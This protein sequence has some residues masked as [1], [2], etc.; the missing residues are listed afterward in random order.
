MTKTIVLESIQAADERDIIGRWVNGHDALR[1]S[2]DTGRRRQHIAEL[3]IRITGGN[4]A[5]GAQAVRDWDA[6]AGTPA[7]S[8]AAILEDNARL[9]RKAAQAASKVE[10]YRKRLVTTRRELVATQEA[11]AAAVE[12]VDGPRVAELEQQLADER[13][14]FA[15]EL[16]QLG[17]HLTHADEVARLYKERVDRLHELVSWARPGDGTAVL[18]DHFRAVLNG[19]EMSD[20]QKS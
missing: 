3:I 9:R 15:A 4:R 2:A 6:V 14:R 19:E 12:P 13:A 16:K 7:P 11:A 20:A 10:E 18:V 17:E 8:T 5:R 1:I